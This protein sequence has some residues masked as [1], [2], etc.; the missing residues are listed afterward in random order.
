MPLTIQ[1]NSKNI[2]IPSDNQEVITIVSDLLKDTGKFTIKDLREGY[3]KYY[4]NLL[5]GICPRCVN[6]TIKNEDNYCP[7][8]GLKIVGL[9]DG[10]IQ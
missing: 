8:C 10:D 7:I 2:E 9:K 5:Q 4:W 3:K 1:I 6:E